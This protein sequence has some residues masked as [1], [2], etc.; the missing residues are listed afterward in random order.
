[1]SGI[2]ENFFAGLLSGLEAVLQADGA[3]EDQVLRGGILAVRAEVAQA[4]ELVGFRG[5]GASQRGLCLAVGEHLQRVGVQA[6][7]KILSGGI[8]IGVVE[9]VTVLAGSPPLLSG[10]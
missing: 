1:M 4:H 6:G 2:R 5:F 3:V 8:G 10:S 9:E 7:Q